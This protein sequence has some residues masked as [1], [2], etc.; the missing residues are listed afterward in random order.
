[1]VCLA[2]GGGYQRAFVAIVLKA[3]DVVDGRGVMC[4]FIED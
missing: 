4:V 2:S 3:I 1:M